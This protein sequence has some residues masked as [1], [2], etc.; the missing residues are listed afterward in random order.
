MHQPSALE[1]FLVTFGAQFKIAYAS[2]P[3]IH[4]SMRSLPR[5]PQILVPQGM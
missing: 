3:V 2:D 4:V 5:Q 1:Q